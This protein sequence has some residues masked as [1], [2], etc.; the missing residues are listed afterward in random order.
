MK[1]TKPDLSKLNPKNINIKKLKVKK[2]F[3]ILGIIII[4]GIVALAKTF[5]IPK[6]A[7]VSNYTTLQKSQI[8][9]SIS[10]SGTIESEKVTKVYAKVSS[11]VEQ[12]NV[13]VG[14]KVNEGDVLALLDSEKIERDIKLSQEEIAQDK[15]TSALDLASKKR[16]YEAILYQDKSDMNTDINAAENDL[17]D[18]KVSLEEAQSNYEYNKELFKYGEVSEQVLR[19]AETDLEAA[20]S[21]YDQASVTLENAQITA[22]DKVQAAKE[23]LEAAQLKANDRS[24]EMALED[25]QKDLENCT[26]K[27]PISGTITSVKAVEGEESTGVLFTIENLDDVFI[28]APIKEVDILNVKVGQRVEIET[29]VMEDGEFVEGEIVSVSDTA[30]KEISTNSS[31]S[32]TSVNSN[33]EA[34]VKIK[35]KSESIKVGM[36][37]RTKIIMSEKNDIYVV[38][39]ECILEGENGACIYIAQPID[40]DKYIIEEVPVTTGIE[41]DVNIEISGDKLT[42]NLNIINEPTLYP[43]GTKVILDQSMTMGGADIE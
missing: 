9:N 15:S 12:V 42:D 21:A 2:K 7:T 27:A 1:L 28:K 38:P 31:E 4:L 6:Y 11:N 22:K 29:D 37:A 36:S 5:L 35:E 23:E 43:I 25:K 41:S 3:I 34:K 19:K 14:D 33:F 24:K 20:K 30:Q 32:N 18:K 39:T 40:G 16:A 13:E 8:V 17:Q 10:A 26:I